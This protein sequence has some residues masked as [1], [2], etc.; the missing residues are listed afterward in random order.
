MIS[1][2]SRGLSRVF[3]NTIV[4]KHQFFS[5][6]HLSDSIESFREK[7]AR[8]RTRSIPE[9]GKVSTFRGFAVWQERWAPCKETGSFS[10]L[11]RGKKKNMGTGVCIVV[12][13][14]DGKM[15]RFLSH[16]IIFCI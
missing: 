13:F 4:Q 5:A 6:E 10:L 15:S 14:R 12:K 8:H 3:S 11:T 2:L 1:L 9:P 16:T 7:V